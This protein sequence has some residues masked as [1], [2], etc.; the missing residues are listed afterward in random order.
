MLTNQIIIAS[1]GFEIPSFNRKRLAT[2]GSKI[3]LRCTGY[4]NQNNIQNCLKNNPTSIQTTVDTCTIFYENLLINGQH[5][6][7]EDFGLDIYISGLLASL[8][9]EKFSLFIDATKRKNLP[10]I[11][12]VICNTL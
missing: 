11:K 2:L 1:D 7:N 5:L 6:T 12:N 9:Q 8:Q 4:L 10:L 3:F